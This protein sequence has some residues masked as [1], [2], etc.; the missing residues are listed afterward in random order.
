M[1]LKT[2]STFYS[3][4]VEALY[5]VESRINIGFDAF[6]EDVRQ[7]DRPINTFRFEKTASAHHTLAGVMPKLKVAPFKGFQA[8]TVEFGILIPTVRD[9]EKDNHDRP[10]LSNDDFEWWNEVF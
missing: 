6:Y 4:I 9:P 10:F 8:I 5:G 7:G 3:E 1:A 2:R